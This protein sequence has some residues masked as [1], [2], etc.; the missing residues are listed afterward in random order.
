[1]GK[2]HEPIHVFRPRSLREAFALLKEHPAAGFFAGGTDAMR[3][4]GRGEAVPLPGAVVSLAEVDELTKIRRRENSVEIGAAVPLER[5][6]SLGANV[7]PTLLLRVLQRIATPPVRNL[8]TLGGNIV[9]AS[10]SSDAILPL[11]LLDA[12]CE[13]RRSAAHTW[14]PLAR[15]IKGPGRT[16]LEA[17]ELL[18][19]VSIPLP[20]WNVRLYEKLDPL[21]RPAPSLLR[22]AAL[23]S[24]SKATVTDF[25][26]IWGGLDPLFLRNR[27]IEALVIGAK[28]PVSPKLAGLFAERVAGLL[29]AAP[30]GFLP[31]AFHRRSAVRL[32]RA[33]LEKVSAYREA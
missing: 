4:A 13:L 11:L 19:A 6:I 21:D 15:F 30:E 29:E 25:R 8:A 5:I 9:L 3:R 22:F 1:M 14:L 18:A 32:A 23:A 12:R 20:R 24:V 16:A 28:T 27:E 26:L 31:A 33:F 17:L 7:V 2:D 10:P